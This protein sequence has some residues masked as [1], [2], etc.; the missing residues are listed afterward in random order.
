MYVL[1]WI[2]LFILSKYF[3]FSRLIFVFWRFL[4]DQIFEQIL[5]KKIKWSYEW[6]LCRLTTLNVIKIWCKFFFVFIVTSDFVQ[7]NK[8]VEKSFWKIIQSTRNGPT[9]TL[10][11]KYLFN[12]KA[13]SMYLWFKCKTCKD[14]CGLQFFF[15]AQVRKGTNHGT[16]SN[17][18]QMKRFNSHLPSK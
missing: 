4:Q 3:Y 11:A 10:P 18:S 5:D 12:S 17:K 8:V 2:K 14:N 6:C 16:E 15:C 13:V 9:L 7:T 1:F